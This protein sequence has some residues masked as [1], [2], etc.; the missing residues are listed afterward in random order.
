MPCGRPGARANPLATERLDRVHVG[1]APRTELCFS[2]GFVN[3][4]CGSV[5]LFDDHRSER[6]VFSKLTSIPRS[7]E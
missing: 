3:V 2:P 5:S 1:R 4:I 6:I 7:V